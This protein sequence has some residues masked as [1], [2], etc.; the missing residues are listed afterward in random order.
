M[1]QEQCFFELA[2]FLNETGYGSRERSGGEAKWGQR[3]YTS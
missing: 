2:D 3:E 1:K